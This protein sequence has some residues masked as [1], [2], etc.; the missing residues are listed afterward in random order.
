M[1][2]EIQEGVDRNNGTKAPPT[3]R[4]ALALADREGT[5]L[6]AR[7]VLALANRDVLALANREVLADTEVLTWVD[8][9]APVSTNEKVLVLADGEIVV[10]GN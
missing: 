5:I 4:G 7:D 9:K 1:N 8:I 2:H 10:I 3:D 6:A